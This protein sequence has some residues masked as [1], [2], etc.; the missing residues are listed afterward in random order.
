MH[1]LLLL[2][3]HKK[4]QE[5]VTEFLKWIEVSQNTRDDLQVIFFFGTIKKTRAEQII[6]HPVS[7]L[8]MVYS[9]SKLVDVELTDIIV[10]ICVAAALFCWKKK[11]K[12]YKQ[13]KK[14]S[15]KI[16]KIP[17]FDFIIFISKR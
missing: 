3:L 7:P 17:I 9:G 12:N 14:E 15:M 13:K 11:I 2:N 10:Y 16:Y 8:L 4:I 6:T 1:S 5:Q